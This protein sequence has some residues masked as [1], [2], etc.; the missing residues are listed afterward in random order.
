M[1]KVISAKDYIEQVSKRNVSIYLQKQDKVEEIL[2]EVI[3]KGDLALYKYAKEFDGVKDDNFSLKVSKDE[4]ERAFKNIN[5]DIRSIIDE[6]YDNI[7]IYHRK[8][9]EESWH[10][11]RNGAF[12]GQLL[13]PIEKIG[14]YI[15]GGKGI[16][17]STV[18]M[19]CVPAQIAGVNE[20]YIASPPNEIGLIDPSII[21]A[22]SLCGV[23]D[24]FKV[25][26]A[27]AI[28]AFAYGTETVPKVYKIVGPGNL[29]VTTAK[30]LV[31]GDVDIDMIAGPSEIMILTDELT[32]ID[33]LTYDL[34]SQSEH[35]EDASSIILVSNNE[36]A[37]NIINSVKKKVVKSKRRDIL[38]K[39]LTNN[40]MIV[41]Y[42]SLDEA[43]NVI[44]E[45]APEHL[46]I[47]IDID[48]AELSLKIKNVGSIFLGAFTP[49]PV[50]DYFAGSNHSLPTGGTAKFFSPLG[51]YDFQKRTSIIKYSKELF[52]KDYKK[53]A[54]FAEYEGFFEHANSVKIRFNEP[55]N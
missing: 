34:F 23:K 37:N 33:Y 31:Y 1:L 7:T 40:G 43:Y 19:N 44:N 24:I 53:I 41:I 10:F 45:Y 35:S 12:L 47:L 38:T 55:I 54:S 36:T 3:E 32:N 17:P 50:G 48:F 25:G 13:N 18:L 2:K 28:A 20:I 15:P 6:A 52:E 29:F 49:E 46:E 9:K 11:T 26:G 27:G 21:Y 8:E 16:Y 30:K 4:I 42:N 5:N 14:A 39:S 51:V 22:A